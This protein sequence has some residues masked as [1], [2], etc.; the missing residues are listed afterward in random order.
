MIGYKTESYKRENQQ[1]VL[2]K[3][4]EEEQTETPENIL[5]VLGWQKAAALLQ[6][7]FENGKIH[8]G[9]VLAKELTEIRKHFF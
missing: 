6:D 5:R 2:Y 4:K 9:D 7:F 3:E 8:H 1:L